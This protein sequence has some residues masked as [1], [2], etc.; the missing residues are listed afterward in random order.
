MIQGQ[1]VRLRER[2]PADVLRETNWNT[3]ELQA[4]DPSVDVIQNSWQ[5]SI[6]TLAGV[7][8]GMCAIYNV[9]GSEGQL[10]IR[11]GN[12]DYWDKGYGTDAVDVLTNHYLTMGGLTRIWL[13]VLPVNIRAIRCYAKCGFKEYGKL[14]L[15]GYEFTVMEGRRSGQHT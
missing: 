14:A 13:K 7:H 6:E 12:K 2:R 3:P 11:I 1:K 15:G 10:G 4:L 9:S 5:Y 8:I